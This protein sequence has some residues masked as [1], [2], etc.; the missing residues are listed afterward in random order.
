MARGKTTAR[1][2]RRTRQHVIADLGVNYLERRVLLRG[3]T[4]E[5]IRHDYGIDLAMFTYNQSGEVESGRVLFQVKATDDLKLLADGSTISF[6]IER[7]DLKRW[8][9]EPDPLIL[10]VYDGKHDRA[11]WLYVQAYFEVKRRMDLFTSPGRVTV[12]IPMANRLNQRAIN[13]FARYRDNVL[14][15]IEGRIRHAG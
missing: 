1:S 3:F 4:I 8:L 12:H 13:R 9:R 2:K 15:Q 5:R 14:T 6:R 11:F 7:S 10:V